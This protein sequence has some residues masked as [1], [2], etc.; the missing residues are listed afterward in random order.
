[1]GLF[2][3]LKKKEEPPTRTLKTEEFTAV[4]INYYEENIKK[5]AVCN[6][7]WKSRTATIV[8]NGKAWQKIFRYNFIN[9]PVKLVPEPKN[10]ADKN[11][12]QVIIAGELVGYISREENVHVKDILS[13]H[14]V[15]YISAF[16]SGGEYK[17]VSENGDMFKDSYSIKVNVK[18]GYV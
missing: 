15:K 9:K 3:F 1:M 6:E 7:D 12:V 17:V 2:D 10:K 13:K 11:A 8:K 14:E 18:I 5:L 16:I 4:G